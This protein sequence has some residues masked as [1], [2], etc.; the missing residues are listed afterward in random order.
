[1]RLRLLLIKKTH[2]RIKISSKSIEFT[3]IFESQWLR[4]SNCVDFLI[5]VLKRDLNEEIS[6]WTISYS[7][8][9]SLTSISDVEI[10]QSTSYVSSFE[11][12]E[13]R[14][15]REDCRSL[16]QH[17][18]EWTKIEKFSERL[19]D[20][21]ALTVHQLNTKSIAVELSTATYSQHEDEN[22]RRQ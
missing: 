18:I 12:V 8:T 10:E 1:M 3:D 7:K 19:A 17:D 4:D 11:C 21:S 22:V 15:V 13:K 9:S 2:L 20:E 14:C 6:N 16:Y 5:V